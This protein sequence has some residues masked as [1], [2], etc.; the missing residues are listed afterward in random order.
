MR[1]SNKPEDPHD[2]R[3]CRAKALDLLARREHAQVELMAKLEARGFAADCVADVA[4][5]LVNE[6]LQD[7]G[8]FAEAFVRARV[9]RG[10]GPLRIRGELR[11]RGVAALLADGALEQAGHDW[12]EFAGYAR[13]KRF[14]FAAPTN[15]AERSRQQ[16]FL[17]TRG[18][19]AEQIRSALDLAG[20]S[21]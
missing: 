4:A 12:A 3:A 10:Q 16:R 17:E 1:F 21:D 9:T 13:A 8:R 20:D 5:Q 11:A 2:S 6:G 19:S 15:P 7:D 14:G 18:F